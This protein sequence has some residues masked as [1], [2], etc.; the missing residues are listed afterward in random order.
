[1][2]QSATD[3]PRHNF[4]HSSDFL[5]R[6]ITAPGSSHMQFDIITP[7]VLTFNE[8]PNIG[9]TLEKLGWASQ[10]VIID[11][12]STDDTLEII[13]RFPNA[14]V[15]QRRFDNFVDQ[16][17]YGLAQVQTEWVLSLDADYVLT[18]DLMAEIGRLPDTP[19]VDG[20]FIP[21]KYCV[22]GK[23]L[24]GSL[25]PPRLALFRR[26]A[27]VYIDDGHTQLLRLNGRSGRLSGY[28]HH[29]DRKSLARWL[30]NQERYVA[31]E[32]RKFSE[33]GA[34]GFNDRLR[35]LKILAPF[36]VFFYCLVV[37][38]GIFDGWAGFHYALQRMLAEMLLSIKLIEEN[39]LFAKDSAHSSKEEERSIGPDSF[40]GSGRISP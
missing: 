13:G 12:Y 1:M 32:A 15:F 11:S 28:I 33:A 17:N 37:K 25:Y 38:R 35:K 26:E 8:S 36:L 3:K 23:P 7:L 10:I 6:Q 39:N 24:S 34:L 18:D 30:N 31:S 29:D 14:T 4:R 5:S 16:W 40:S 19:E 22:F 2:K 27:G 21:F 9:R 20:F